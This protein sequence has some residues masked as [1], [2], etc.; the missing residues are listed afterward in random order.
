MYIKL[1]TCIYKRASL[2][3][4]MLCYGHGD[5]SSNPVRVMVTIYSLFQ[6]KISNRKKYH[7]LDYL[8]QLPL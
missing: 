8:K 2:M 3:V 5:T 1:Y 4:K 6:I 7:R